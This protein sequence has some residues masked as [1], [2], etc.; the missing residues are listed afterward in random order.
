MFT[1]MWTSSLGSS[2]PLSL[3]VG[4]T[5]SPAGCISQP[6]WR[7]GRWSSQCNNPPP[8]LILFLSK[9]YVCAAVEMG[10]FDVLLGLRLFLLNFWTLL[11]GVMVTAQL[12]FGLFKHLIQSGLP[13]SGLTPPRAHFAKAHW[14]KVG[15]YKLYFEITPSLESPDYFTA[16][17]CLVSCRHASGERCGDVFLQQDMNH[18]LPQLSARLDSVFPIFTENPSRAAS[19]FRYSCV[20]TGKLV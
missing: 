1:V 9:G 4:Q 20:S 5:F 15:L 3:Q 12:V 8:K 7:A 2:A 17:P 11:I 18:Q 19:L 13:G 6:R 10:L 14:V 16:I